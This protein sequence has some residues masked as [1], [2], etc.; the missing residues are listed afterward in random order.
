MPST[1]VNHA[2]RLTPE[3]SHRVNA[4]QLRGLDDAQLSPAKAIN[5]Q[6]S[7]VYTRQ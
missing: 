7:V 6:I 2:D 4:I 3:A 5:S 1:N